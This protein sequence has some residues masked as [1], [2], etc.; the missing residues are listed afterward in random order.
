M[1]FNRTLL[2]IMFGNVA[3][4]TMKLGTLASSLPPGPSPALGERY[5]GLVGQIRH[6]VPSRKG[7]NSQELKFIHGTIRCILTTR[8]A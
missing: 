1:S 4:G 6:L 8:I 3:L 7:R 2:K 5:D